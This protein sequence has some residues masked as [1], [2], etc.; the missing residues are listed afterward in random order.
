[1]EWDGFGGTREMVGVAYPKD[2][3]KKFPS[4]RVEGGELLKLLWGNQKMLRE[5]RGASGR[6]PCFRDTLESVSRGKKCNPVE[7]GF[8]SN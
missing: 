6:G 4:L 3:R 2:T 7:I 8:Q 5:Y 1:M